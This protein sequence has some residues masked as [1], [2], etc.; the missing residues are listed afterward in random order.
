MGKCCAVYGC[1]SD[2]KASENLE[3][4]ALF[5]APKDV[6][7][8]SKWSSALGKELKITSFICELHFNPEDVIKSNQGV[9]K[10]GSIY[11]YE[12][13]KVHLKKNA[14]A[15]SNATNNANNNEDNYIIIIY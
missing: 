12:Y 11:V 14:I 15:K 7:M 9:L 2:R 13:D 3:N 4:V 8:L 6:E 1:L 5:K 10:N